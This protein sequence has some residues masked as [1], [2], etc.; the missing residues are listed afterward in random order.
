[1][2]EKFILEEQRSK[3]LLRSMTKGN[4]NAW[5]NRDSLRENLLNNSEHTDYLS[6]SPKV[7]HDGMEDMDYRI[8]VALD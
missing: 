8:Q 7:N 2:R 6:T 3:S 4:Y 1:M 5:T